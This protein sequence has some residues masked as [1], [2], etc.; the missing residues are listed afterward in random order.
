MD[1][2][3]VKCLKSP[4]ECSLYVFETEVTTGGVGNDGMGTVAMTTFPIGAQGS[5]TGSQTSVVVG[6]DLLHD[7]EQLQNV[8]KRDG[9]EEEEEEEEEKE[10]GLPAKILRSDTSTPEPRAIAPALEQGGGGE[11]GG[12]ERKVVVMEWHTCAIC[13]EEM[14]DEDLLTH[15]D[16]GA[17]LCSSCLQAAQQH[18][19]KTNSSFPC[20]VSVHCWEWSVVASHPHPPLSLPPPYPPSLPPSLLHQVCQVMVQLTTFTPLAPEEKSKSVVR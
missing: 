8:N 19:G 13:L 18:S 16:C 15:T 12:G 11:G 20:P 2:L 3:A 7:S 5:G 4:H 6:A 1:T 10:E 14:E 17:I 9:K